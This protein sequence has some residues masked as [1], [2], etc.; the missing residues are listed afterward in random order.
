MIFGICM[1]SQLS[2]FS[3]KLWAL[4]WTA[5][6]LACGSF[7]LATG[8]RVQRHCGIIEFQG[9]KIPV[10]LEL[11]PGGACAAIT[12]GHVVLGRSMKCLD[13]CRNHELV[14]VRQYERWGPLFIPAYL[15]CSAY[16]WLRGGD[17]YRDNPFERE[18]SAVAA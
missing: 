8:G 12:L 10:L 17:A 5:I 4:P 9:G 3:K 7:G 11:L 6:G 13:S 16:I 18:A 2:E 15:A 1:G 14:H